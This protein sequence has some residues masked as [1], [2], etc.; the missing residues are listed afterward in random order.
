MLE[1][2]WWVEVV[3][4][5]GGGVE[6]SLGLVVGGGGGGVEDV[7]GE[8]VGVG[9]SAQSQEP[10]ITPTAVGAKLANSPGDKSSPP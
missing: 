1:V 6:V 7:V 2:L 10:E 3:G 5:G 4:G 9:P 8:G